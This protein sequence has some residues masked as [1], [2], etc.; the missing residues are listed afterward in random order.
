MFGVKVKITSSN[1]NVCL[2]LKEQQ[3]KYIIYGQLPGAAIND[4]NITYDNSYL[5]IT[6]T[7]TQSIT[8]NGTGCTFICKKSN[9]ILKSFYIPDLDPKKVRSNFDGVN[10]TITGEK[11][12]ELCNNINSYN[13]DKIVDVDYISE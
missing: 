11:C 7:S 13:Y 10:I 6:A 3:D 9:N 1:N 4:I 12:K 5:T 2:D 8:N